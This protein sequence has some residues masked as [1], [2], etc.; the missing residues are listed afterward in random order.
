MLALGFLV[1]GCYDSVRTLPV[2]FIPPPNTQHLVF[3]KP[4]KNGGS[5]LINW[6]F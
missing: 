1:G 5:I 2:T 3:R 6:L 4:S